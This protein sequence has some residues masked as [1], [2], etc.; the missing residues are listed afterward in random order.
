MHAH[1]DVPIAF[2]IL[3]VY[4]YYFYLLR[5]FIN[6]ISVL[7]QLTIIMFC[8]VVRVLLC[9]GTS[10]HSDY[11]LLFAIYDYGVSVLSGWYYECQ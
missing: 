10:G 4:Y 11:V 7:M 3:I 6:I 5:L 1:Y 9:I 2:V 8:H